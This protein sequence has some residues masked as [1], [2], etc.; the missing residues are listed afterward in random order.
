MEPK[1]TQ[2]E[3]EVYYPEH[4]QSKIYIQA[5]SQL[6]LTEIDLINYGKNEKAQAE[7]NAKLIAAAPR[8]FAILDRLTSDDYVME[9]LS[10]ALT[11]EMQDIIN[12]ITA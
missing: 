1:F 7:A 5:E 10:G 2:G 6:P 3:W 8:M 9:K 12:S 11:N 4:N